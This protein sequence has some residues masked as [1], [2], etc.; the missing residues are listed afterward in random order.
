MSQITVEIS[1][2]LYKSICGHTDNTIWS[3]E[4]PYVAIAIKNSTLLNE[5]KD[6]Y[7]EQQY[8]R[9]CKNKGSKAICT[10]CY[11]EPSMF[12]RKEK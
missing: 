4:I 12:D 11:Y 3:S 5:G 6:S 2:D 1:E 9:Y 7:K 8:C 10:S